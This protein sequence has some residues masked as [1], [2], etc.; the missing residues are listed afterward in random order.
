MKIEAR[1][2]Q[3]VFSQKLTRPQFIEIRAGRL[4]NRRMDLGLN[5]KLALIT[6]STAGIGLAIAEGL[7]A[8]GARVV[9]NGRTQTR[10]DAAIAAIKDKQPKADVSGVAAD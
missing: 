7:A 6:G 5:G 8:E 4:Y 1:I 3:D 9:V 2:P 10:I